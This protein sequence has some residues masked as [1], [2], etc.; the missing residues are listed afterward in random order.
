MDPEITWSEFQLAWSEQRWSDAAEYAVA[1]ADWLESGGF[2]PKGM[3]DYNGRYD[4][5]ALISWMGSYRNSAER[6]S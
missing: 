1:L 3:E 5:A 6:D 4:R 2:I